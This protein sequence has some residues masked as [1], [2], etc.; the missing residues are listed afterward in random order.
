VRP[1]GNQADAPQNPTN[2][3]KDINYFASPVGSEPSLYGDMLEA[4]LHIGGLVV[5]SLPQRGLSTQFMYLRQ[6]I[7]QEYTGNTNIATLDEYGTVSYVL[8]FNLEKA[9]RDSSFSGISLMAGQT[10]TLTLTNV[11]PPNTPA[12][13]AQAA[14]NGIGALRGVYMTYIYDCV[15]DISG[16]GAS[17]QM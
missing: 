3:L 12:A 8:G 1:Y 5:P 2:A 6:C 10:C 7:H 13:V 14:Q 9:G 4:Q 17:V 15:F 16:A 11:L